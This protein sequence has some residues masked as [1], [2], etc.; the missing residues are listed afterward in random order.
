M[1]VVPAQGVTGTML[2]SAMTASTASQRLVASTW[3]L[4]GL[5]STSLLA[6]HSE[7]IVSTAFIALLT[8]CGTFGVGM[9]VATLF[10]AMFGGYGQGIHMSG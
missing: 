8:I 6:Q 1:A 9:R 2:S 5:L 4:L 7:V 3:G 10:T